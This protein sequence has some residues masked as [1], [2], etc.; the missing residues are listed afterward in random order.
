MSEE[1][2]ITENEATT[3]PVL[4]MTAEG[5]ESELK[6]Y[7]VNYTGIKLETEQEITNIRW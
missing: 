5:G 4:A 2:I 3:N 1:K 6:E 7:L